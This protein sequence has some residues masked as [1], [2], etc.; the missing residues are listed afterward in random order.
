MSRWIDENFIS[1]IE[2]ENIFGENEFGEGGE[3]VG[4]MKKQEFMCK[5]KFWKGV[6]DD[7]KTEKQEIDEVD[8]GGTDVRGGG[9]L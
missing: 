5:W 7:E 9:T 3:N 2:A 8:L 4:K 1:T 6:R